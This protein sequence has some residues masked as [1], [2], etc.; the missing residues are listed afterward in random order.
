MF[1][2]VDAT[3]NK[4]YLI[5]SVESLEIISTIIYIANREK[6]NF[7]FFWENNLWQHLQTNS[8]PEY[9]GVVETA[10]CKKS[11]V[12]TK[13]TNLDSYTFVQ[14]F[15]SIK[16]G[17]FII[18]DIIEKD[19]LNIQNVDIEVEKNQICESPLDSPFHFILTKKDIIYELQALE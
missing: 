12:K 14:K 18:S 6:K 1:F 15:L 17:K 13:H 11:C 16:N 8:E 4:T 2:V 7:N 19:R 3:Q 5:R 9:E 10:Y